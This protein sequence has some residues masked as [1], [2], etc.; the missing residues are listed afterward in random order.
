MDLLLTRDYCGSEPL[1]GWRMRAEARTLTCSEHR[2]QAVITGDGFN[3]QIPA[4]YGPVQM[5]AY[6]APGETQE[7]CLSWFLDLM[8]LEL[9]RLIRE[10]RHD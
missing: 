1:S 8:E 5:P 9:A 7:E 2:T 6:L 10:G 3:Q 4:R